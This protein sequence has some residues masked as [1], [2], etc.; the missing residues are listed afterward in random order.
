MCTQ[1]Q[2]NPLSLFHHKQYLLHVIDPFFPLYGQ[3]VLER[4]FNQNQ[5]RFMA[6]FDTCIFVVVIKSTFLYK[7]D[8]RTKMYNTLFSLHTIELSYHRG[9][10]IATFM[11][12]GNFNFC[13]CAK[14]FRRYDFNGTSVHFFKKRTLVCYVS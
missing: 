1:S 11:L 13:I 8:F 7:N 14:L 6:I 4:R 9:G 2:I 12:L 5:I 10:D 3:I